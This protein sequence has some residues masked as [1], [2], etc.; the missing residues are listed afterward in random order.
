[1]Q[2]TLELPELYFFNKSNAQVSQEVK[3]ALA[4]WMYQIG[5]VSAGGACEIA[6]IDRYSFLEIC[7]KYHISTINYDINEIEDELTNFKK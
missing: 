2:I 4:L 1:M 7:T 3:L 6:D 5:E